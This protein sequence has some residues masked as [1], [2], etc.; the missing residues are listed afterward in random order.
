MNLICHHCMLAQAIPNTALEIDCLV[1]QNNYIA[2]T[3]VFVIS[4]SKVG[5]LLHWSRT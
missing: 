5:T 2:A 4:P 3:V 1:S